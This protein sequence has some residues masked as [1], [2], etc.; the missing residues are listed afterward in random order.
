MVV[1]NLIKVLTR[2]LRGTQGT[3]DPWRAALAFRLGVWVC[4]G[5]VGQPLGRQVTFES[6]C[7]V[8]WG[9]LGSHGASL[10]PSVLLEAATG[11][12]VVVL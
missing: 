2:W 6:S 3:V 12:S 11:H 5:T 7:C 4:T 9:T 10:L 1:T 8:V